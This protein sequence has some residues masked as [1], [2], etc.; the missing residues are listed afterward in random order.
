MNKFRAYATAN[1][2]GGG[3]AGHT[4]QPPPGKFRLVFA[5]VEG[6]DALSRGIPPAFAHMPGYRDAWCWLTPAN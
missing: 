3:N 4:E 1:A 2:W 5:F 6:N